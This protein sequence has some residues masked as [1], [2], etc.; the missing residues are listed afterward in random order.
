MSY[1]LEALKK[2]EPDTDPDAAVARVLQ[3]TQAVRQQRWFIVIAAALILNL[4]VLLALFQPWKSAGRVD[5]LRAPAASAQ[6]G[7]QSGTISKA[8]RQPGP[9]ADTGAML[10]ATGPQPPAG[11]AP[12]LDPAI[13]TEPQAPGRAAAD[14]PRNAWPATPETP[15]SAAQ[16]DLPD[17]RSGS[18]PATAEEPEGME[19][20]VYGDWPDAAPAA[21]APVV[22]SAA[23]AITLDQ[24]PAADR[25]AFPPM[26]FSTHVYAEDQDL[27]ALVI[28]GKRHQEGDFIGEA[29]LSAITET[30]ALISYRGH[31]IRI[32]IIDTWE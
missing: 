19:A 2:E 1:I 26:V 29:Q 5:A 3:E 21:A 32:P 16:L 14:A 9:A 25:S 22:K 7:N 27:R 4:A 24:L 8:E 18:T 23:P 28:N 17:G 6:P 31:R 13:A 15:S 11:A 10:D 30:G 12:E 20:I